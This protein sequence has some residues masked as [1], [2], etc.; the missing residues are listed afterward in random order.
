MT[1]SIDLFY[2]ITNR[3]FFNLYQSVID[4]DIKRISI[5]S[6]LNATKLSEFLNFLYVGFPD[7][8]S[9]LLT[10]VLGQAPTEAEVIRDT[11]GLPFNNMRIL[12][13]NIDR[14]NYI[15]RFD[16]IKIIWLSR[17]YSGKMMKYSPPYLYVTCCVPNEELE[18]WYIK[19]NEKNYMEVLRL[20]TIRTNDNPTYHQALARMTVINGLTWTVNYNID[21]LE[22]ALG[23]PKNVVDRLISIQLPGRYSDRE[24][25][26]IITDYLT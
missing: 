17:S 15:K 20:M 13:F 12:R 5:L 21:F 4:K 7:Y 1:E 6:S 25:M 18:R 9:M 14:Y 19:V 22:T 16:L 2:Y 26:Q 3:K 23:L 24:F 8:P 10:A 11:F